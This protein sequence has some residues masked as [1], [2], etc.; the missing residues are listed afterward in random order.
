MGWDEVENTTQTTIR[1]FSAGVWPGYPNHQIPGRLDGSE[2]MGFSSAANMIWLGDRLEK[3]F[4]WAQVQTADLDGAVTSAHFTQAHTSENIVGTAG[5]KIYRALHQAAPVDATGAVTVTAGATVKW[6]DWK[7]GSTSYAIAVSNL[8]PP[9]KTPSGGVSTVL[10][11]THGVTASG[12]IA[13]WQNS[14][15]LVDEDQVTLRFSALGDPENWDALDNYV[16]N[17][18]IRDIK[19]FGN[20]LVV[21]K[22]DSIGILYGTNNRQLTKVDEFVTGIGMDGVKE[23]AAGKL[24]SKDVLFFPNESGI[25][26][27]DGTASVIKISTSLDYAFNPGRITPPIR[28]KLTN[29][30]PFLGLTYVP[31]YSWL[32]F[33]FINSITNVTEFVILDLSNIKQLDAANYI[34]PAW[35]QTGVVGAPIGGATYALNKFTTNTT[36]EIYLWGPDFGL[37]LMNSTL[38]TKQFSNGGVASAYTASGKTKILDLQGEFLVQE[39]DIEQAG[40]SVNATQIQVGYDMGRGTTTSTAVLGDLVGSS[41]PTKEFFYNNVDSTVVTSN[42]NFGRW[43]NFYFS[44]PQV[45]QLPS[46]EGVTLVMTG[47]GNDSNVKNT[48]N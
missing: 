46:V 9:W 41:S 10:G 48:N 29:T 27:F 43:L 2:P 18:P 24:G 34:A 47:F 14:L 25:W 17:T 6:V 3:M 33:F 32:L 42:F 44:A 8:N 22:R 30:T 31:D 39:L 36:P 40:H 11:G 5:A 7:F 15:W 21:F 38:T 4:G 35:P 20:M 16:F 13:A 45:S 26:A 1:D 37:F 23:A 19:S 28:V 12:G